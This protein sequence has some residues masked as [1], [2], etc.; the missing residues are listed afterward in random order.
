MLLSYRGSF[1]EREGAVKV[2]RSER[3]SLI[4]AGIAKE[5]ATV[6][7]EKGRSACVR[8]EQCL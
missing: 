8:G 3:D 5:L 2:N 7:L 1:A 4:E 6:A